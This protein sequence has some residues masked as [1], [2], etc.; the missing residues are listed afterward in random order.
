MANPNFTATMSSNEIWRDLDDTRCITDDLDTIE[1]NITA[2]QTGKANSDHTHSGYANATHTHTE[3]AP[4]SHEHNGYAPTSHGHSYND[5][6][7]KPEIPDAYTHPENH[8]ASMIIGLATVATTGN[9]DDLNG[10]PTIPTIPA[11]LPANGGNA[12]TVDG[13]HATDFAEANHKHTTH[14][15]DITIEKVN[16]PGI[17]LQ[18]TNSSGVK[19][20]IHKNCNETSDYGTCISDYDA[21]GKRDYLVLRRASPSVS[22]KLMLNV[23]DANGGATEMYQIYGEHNKPGVLWRGTQYVTDTSTVTPSK[24]L[25]EC[26]TGWMLLWSDYDAD[27]TTAN[28]GEFVTTMIPRITPT[29]A[30]WNGQSF[31]CEIPRFIGSDTTDVDTEKRIIKIVYIYNDKI[32]GHS[33]NNK[34]TRTDVVLRAVYEF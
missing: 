2:L 3:Y 18:A 16:G 14:N 13:K 27:T 30:N 28:D 23:E 34:G 6:S 25:S 32:T 10:T 20:R 24:A 19:T 29:G 8:P 11:S 26:R 15:G 7:D 33:A 9:Y 5:L 12:D 17:N 1:S 21:N 31:S 22:G 4:S